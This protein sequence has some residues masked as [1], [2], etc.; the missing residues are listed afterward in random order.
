MNTKVG[1]NNNKIRRKHDKGHRFNNLPDL[2]KNDEVRLHDGHSWGTKGKVVEPLK[3]FP[4]SY[5]VE[6]DKGKI[7]RRNRK[8]I[9]LKKEENEDNNEK[10]DDEYQLSYNDRPNDTTSELVSNNDN[11]IRE[12]PSQC[13]TRSGRTI[14]KPSR[15]EDYVMDY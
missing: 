7:L 3:D 15:Y 2:Q 5:I 10:F 1:I 13:R 6:T 14:R 9:L 8:H 11:E 4:R 12:P